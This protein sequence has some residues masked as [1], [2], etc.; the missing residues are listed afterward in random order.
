MLR[1]AHCLL[2]LVVWDE[3]TH[4]LIYTY[5]DEIKEII[6]VRAIAEELS[7]LREV[8]VALPVIELS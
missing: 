1:S 6:C 3:F 2:S 4:L 5:I 7:F 8:K